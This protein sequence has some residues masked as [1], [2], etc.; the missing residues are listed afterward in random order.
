MKIKRL[1]IHNIASI[2][3]AR[4]DFTTPPLADSDVFLIT[5]DT[6]SGKS[7]ILDAISL[8]LYAT[9]PR[10]KDTQMQGSISD[11]GT[12]DIQVDDPRRLLREETGE[13]SVELEFEGSNGIPYKAVW[14]VHRAKN[15][16]SGRLQ[17]KDWS[18][19]NLRSGK[20]LNKDK[21]IAAEIASATGLSS[22]D[23]FCRTTMLA[24]GEFTRFLNSPD[25]EKAA[26]L[27]K[28]TGADIYARIGARIYAI[29][30]QKDKEYAK[31]KEDAEGIKPLS[32]EE[33]EAKEN[34]KKTLEELSKA[35]GEKK[36]TC[37]AQL[38]FLQDEKQLEG[39]IRAAKDALAE[40]EKVV[41]TDEFAEKAALVRKYE[42]TVE[43]RGHLAT[44]EK[45]KQDVADAEKEIEKLA[46]E[47]VTV[48]AGLAYLK[49]ERQEKQA[50]LDGIQA[51]LEREK[52]D[53]PV[54]EKAQT[55]EAYRTT[56]ETGETKIKK[57]GEEI[58]SIQKAIDEV[59]TPALAQAEED[60][61]KAKAT[62][63][64]AEAATTEAE[65][66]R[67]A[68]NLGQVRMDLTQ[69]RALAAEIGKA[70]LR[71]SAWEEAVKAREK[72][73]KEI[74]RAD[75]DLS[76]LKKEADGLARLCTDKTQAF[77]VWETAYDKVKKAEETQVEA[78]RSSLSVG[79]VC[80]VC[81]RIIESALPSAAEISAIVRP[82]KDAYD[83]AKKEK[84][85]AE[86]ELDAAGSRIQA[87]QKALD[88]RR[89]AF[90]GENPVPDK[91]ADALA[92][93]RQCGL[94]ELSEATEKDLET[95]L[96]NT[97]AE[98][99]LLGL[100][101]QEG[102]ALEAKENEARN[103]EKVYRTKEENAKREFEKAKDS[104]RKKT[105]EIDGRK[106][107]SEA[108]HNRV[109]EAGKALERLLVG[110]RWEHD[111][112]QDLKAFGEGLDAAV[113]NHKFIVDQKSELE[114]TIF[115]KLN[116]VIET[117]A[118]HLEAVEKEQPSWSHLH[119]SDPEA[120]SGIRNRADVL[121]GNLL[122]QQQVVIMAGKDAKTEND[123]V[124]AFL[125]EHDDY[126]RDS[127]GALS[128][129]NKRIIEIEKQEVEN[130]KEAVKK[131]ERERSIHE[132]N[133][134]KLRETKPEMEEGI[135]EEKLE[136]EI[137]GFGNSITGR[138]GQIAL[139]QKELNDDLENVRQHGD[140]LKKAEELK[141]VSD[142]WERLNDLFGSADG[143]KFRKLAQSY[144]LGSL[145]CA[146][147]EYMTALTDRYTLKVHPGT[148]IIELEDAYQGY[149]SRVASTISGG[150]SFLVSLSL[151]LALSD[152]GT[153]LSVDTLFIDEGF[154][155]LSGDPLQRA[156]DTL[157]SLNKHMGRHVG[158]ISHIKELRE[159]IPVKILVNREGQSSASTVTVEG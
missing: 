28:I 52:P 42:D 36:K 11:S 62:L 135:T 133:L 78:L 102:E 51:A 110:S 95:F 54:I 142:R 146:A 63:G 13:G 65:E 151:A 92:S 27:E 45:K 106:R 1:T 124:E 16:A 43:V 147:N 129:H 105:A 150:E 25:E 4:I 10:M 90:D 125:R 48:H 20:V 34:E 84:E 55:V 141:L 116:P 3:D 35:E 97:N 120:V 15:K 115:E 153:G 64:R 89:K 85:E 57:W 53:L 76:I 138:A 111:W 112:A 156:V 144:V 9:T 80:P 74:D 61:E 2:E 33:R 108:E 44:F 32:R 30:T 40:A 145:V 139:V 96:G 8:A 143:K 31:A 94:F 79:D 123:C 17:G 104:V 18:L 21:E 6:G 73:K 71:V 117:V 38:K 109:T 67:K 46:G 140:L 22:F 128:T 103:V 137:E 126:T 58:E 100:K 122:R 49:R 66:K 39:W 159:K 119:P 113:R 99:E 7:T 149:A 148:F 98:I 131:A 87:D 37:E 132:A 19:T 47:Y 158:I 29:Y 72:E 101:E 77:M 86:R 136:H 81:Q 5:G 75:E 155:T 50:R 127:L 60:W 14:A 59:L 134:F 130:A 154:G 107:L 12:D 82:V 23:Q 152:I 69:K 114:K 24:Q 41:G 88:R 157:K 70:Q 93:L 83:K 91:K 56:V 121:K 26:I 118:G 68:A